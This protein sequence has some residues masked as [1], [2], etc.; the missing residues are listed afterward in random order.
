MFQKPPAEAKSFT[1]MSWAPH[2]L[3][4]SVLL[5]SRGAEGWEGVGLSALHGE[6]QAGKPPCQGGLMWI[7]STVVSP[8]LGGHWIFPTSKVSSGSTARRGDSG[9]AGTALGLCPEKQVNI[10]RNLSY[11]Q[12]QS[13]DPQG[14]GESRRMMTDMAMSALSQ[15]VLLVFSRPPFWSTSPP[16]PS[17]SCSLQVSTLH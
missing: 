6:H 5:C 16:C 10:S 7:T 3:A 12:L 1:T 2:C 8:G 14:P 9:S 17:V 11:T 13:E 4:T 15:P